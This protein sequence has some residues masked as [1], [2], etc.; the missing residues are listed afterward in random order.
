[1]VG[2][3]VVLRERRLIGSMGAFGWHGVVR[4]RWIQQEGQERDFRL[5]RVESFAGGGIRMARPGR[6]GWPAPGRWRLAPGGA[7]ASGA[8]AGWRKRESSLMGMGDSSRLGLRPDRRGVDSSGWNDPSFGP[9]AVCSG[10][11]GEFVWNA[12]ARLPGFGVVLGV[13]CRAGW[14][15][16]VGTAA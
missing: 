13:P 1:M 16:S 7:L 11:E 2:A 8:G 15:R 6:V 12:P 4:V 14:V 5:E 3:S 9:N 10:W